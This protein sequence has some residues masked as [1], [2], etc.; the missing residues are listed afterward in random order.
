MNNLKLELTLDQLNVIMASMGKMP[1]ETVFQVI[2][3]IEIQVQPQ[4]KAEDKSE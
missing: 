1:Y 4:I 3:E 2:R